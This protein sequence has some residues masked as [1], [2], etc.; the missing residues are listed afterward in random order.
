MAD[1]QYHFFFRLIKMSM[2]Q[3]YALKAAFW[4]RL[5]FMIVSDLIMLIGWYVMFQSFHTIN[6]WSFEDFMFMSGLNISTFSIWTLFFRGGGTY[7]AQWIQNGEF[8]HFLL[9]PPNVL[10][11][12]S[13]CVSEPAG[14]GDFITG[15]CLMAVSGLVTFN[16]FGIVLILFICAVLCFLSIS[17]ILTAINFYFKNAADLTERL[18]YVFFC[19]CGYP[20]S[21][22]TDWAK[23][24]LI[25]VFPVGLISILP[26]EILKNM[27]FSS[28]VYLLCATAVLFLGSIFLFY[29]GLRRYES[30]N[31]TILRG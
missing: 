29:R 19:I 23:V 2:K 7:M 8:D 9:S 24:I 26:V 16:T 13:C 18:F 31:R 22:Y 20:G 6:G 11:H 25:T 15:I 30:G 17:F 27:Q 4:L 1:R 10:F 14:W 3:S 21:I 28:F 12:A 5:I